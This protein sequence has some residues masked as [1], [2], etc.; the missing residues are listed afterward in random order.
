MILNLSRVEPNIGVDNDDVARIEGGL[1][2]SMAG[3]PALWRRSKPPRL[4]TP[5]LC[6]LPGLFIMEKGYCKYLYLPA[7][8]INIVHMVMGTRTWGANEDPWFL[9]WCRFRMKE[10]RSLKSG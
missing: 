6:L 8:E 1:N 10:R 2:L 7:G 5:Q 4:H 9:W 3:H